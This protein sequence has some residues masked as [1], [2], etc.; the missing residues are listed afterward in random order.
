MIP[1]GSPPQAP[2]PRKFFSSPVG[3]RTFA[4]TATPSR[5]PRYTSYFARK[6]TSPIPAAV[7]GL[8]T[9]VPELGNVACRHGWTGPQLVTTE[10]SNWWN[11]PPGNAGMFGANG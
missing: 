9:P 1:N 5:S 8:G 11:T 6:I 3:A 7:A 10:G 2:E 4:P